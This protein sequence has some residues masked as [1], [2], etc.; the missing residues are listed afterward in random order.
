[1]LCPR[2]PWLRE[3]SGAGLFASVELGY[4]PG[5][6]RSGREEATRIVNDLRHRGVLIGTTGRDSNVLKIRPPLTIS[7]SEV[8]VLLKALEASLS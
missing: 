8:D 1:M 7:P 6:G 4:H 5:T 3:V 2:Y